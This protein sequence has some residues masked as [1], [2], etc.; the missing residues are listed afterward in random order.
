MRRRVAR[1]DFR[2]LS[3]SAVAATG[4]PASARAPVHAQHTII[5]WLHWISASLVYAP[6]FDAQ[7]RFSIGATAEWKKSKVWE[8]DPVMG[9]YR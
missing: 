4:I 3:G 5:H 6:W 2:Q 7:Q 1:R 8:E 9:L